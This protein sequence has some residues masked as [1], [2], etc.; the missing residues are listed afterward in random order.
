MDSCLEACLEP[1]KIC[2]LSCALNFT[3]VLA[4]HKLCAG[5]VGPDSFRTSTWRM[6]QRYHEEDG[7]KKIIYIFFPHSLLSRVRE[8][9]VEHNI[10]NFNP[11]RNRGSFSTAQNERSV[12]CKRLT[13]SLEIETYRSLGNCTQGDAI[14]ECQKLLKQRHFQQKKKKLFLKINLLKQKIPASDVL[15]KCSEQQA[16]GYSWDTFF[17]PPIFLIEGFSL[18]MND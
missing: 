1:W 15:L 3:A 6:L 2:W 8:G 10:S 18:R 4:S 17:P 5:Y 16:L 9:G 14:K 12:K 7:V 11:K 13:K